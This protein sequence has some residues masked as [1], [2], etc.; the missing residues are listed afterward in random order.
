MKQ[1]ILVPVLCAAL[2]LTG[3]GLSGKRYVSVTP[4]R[5]QRQDVQSEVASASSYLELVQV[6]EEM[7]DDG[8]ENGAVNVAEYP[9]RYVET[10]MAMAA[11]HGMNIY[12]IGAY[13]VEDIHYEVGTSGGL[14]AIAITIT[15]IHSGPE[16]RQIRN[17][18]YMHETQALV[19]AALE[20]YD[21]SLVMKV[22]AYSEIDFQQQVRDYAQDHP[23]TVME[24]P[25]VTVGIYGSGPGRV[26]ELSFAYQNG[27][28]ALRQM[29]NQVEPVFEAAELYVSGDGANRQKYAQ[30]FAFLMERFDYKVETSITPAYSLL[31]HGVGDSRAF[32]TVYAAMCRRAGLECLIV[33][34]TRAGEP[35][36]W[37]II[38]DN[39]NYQHV[40]LLQCSEREAFRGLP[41][42]DMEGY[43]WDYSAYPACSVTRT[44]EP[45]QESHTGGQSEQTA[46]EPDESPEETV[47]PAETEAL[48]TEPAPLPEVPAQTEAAEEPKGQE[49]LP[50]DAEEKTEEK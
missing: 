25:Q 45:E 5:E 50:E 10:G 23:E 7:I 28:D 42:R 46:T 8:V 1:K 16:I 12:P 24:T 40:D 31:R 13:A 2:L 29:K 6:L 49:T 48:E 18:E 22:G 20:N 32:A 27:R 44:P 4:H 33:T 41:D 47:P 17:L 38:H 36:T 21:T 34:G 19:A 39:G 3:C 15:Y 11:A 26:V 35:W 30:L 14:P 43:V 9:Q 37:N